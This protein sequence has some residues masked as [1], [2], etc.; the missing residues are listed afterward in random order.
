MKLRTQIIWISSIAVLLAVL[1]SDAIIFTINKETLQNEAMIKSYQNS[2]SMINK[3]EA[4]LD[5][6]MLVNNIMPDSI[7]L[8]YYFKQSM[9][10][11][12]ICFQGT[13]EY[14]SSEI[15]E[16]EVIEIYNRTVFTA[17]D[18]A[19]LDFQQ[20]E[21]LNCA[22][23]N[24]E[25]RDYLV[26]FSLVKHSLFVY[27]F[28]DIT[29]VKEELTL[30]LLVMLCITLGV[31]AVVVFVLIF[32]LKRVFQP[33]QVLNETTKRMAEGD[34]HQRVGIQS[35]NE[36]G[37][38]GESF[39]SMAEAVE[40]RTRSLEESEQRKTL[41]MGNL[42]HELKTP[43]TAISGYAQTL[44]S[45]RITQEEEEEALT[46]IY[47]ECRRL[48]RLSRK[49]MK[50]LELDQ[51]E[52]LELNDIPIRTIFEAAQQS[53]SVILREK[54]I[55]LEMEEHGEHFC[56]EP[57]LMTD[58]IINLID[59]AVKA[60]R[61]G[62][63][64]CLQAEGNE[65][66]VRDYGQGIPKEEQNKILEPFYMIDKSRSRKHGGAGLGL[67]LTATILNLHHASLRIES[68]MGAGTCMIL[69]F[70]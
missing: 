28:E 5:R 33:L 54:E 61:R 9:D 4:D 37:E 22:K 51:E 46:F 41:F 49:M 20:Y 27:H 42:T 8:N 55:Q 14:V 63:R 35:R 57:D 12:S 11:Y 36:I 59:N 16:E 17:A 25:G 53:C 1:I 15:D 40:V 39:N 31:I 66:R 6:M 52:A 43:M 21:E 45:T 64:I 26:F 44:L 69:Q 56:M 32:V 67:A 70:V 62:G 47:K 19:E 3:L 34:Y 50:L 10:E 30:L 60:S 48:E 13:A 18:L 58:V 24:W 65:I 68:E 29:Y 38:L 2:F 7:Y 23:L